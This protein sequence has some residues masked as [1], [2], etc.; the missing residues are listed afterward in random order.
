MHLDEMDEASH[1]ALTRRQDGGPEEWDSPPHSGMARS[2]KRSSRKWDD[3]QL[4]RPTQTG[5][6]LLFPGLYLGMESRDASRGV[7]QEQRRQNY[8][9]G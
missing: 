9:D 2:L 7:R 8:D 5:P 3:P 1:S 4:G 6:S